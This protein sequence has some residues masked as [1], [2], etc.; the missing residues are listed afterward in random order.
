MLFNYQEILF[1]VLLVLAMFSL[2]VSIILLIAIKGIKRPFSFLL[3]TR[4]LLLI[5][6]FFLSRSIILHSA[7]ELWSFPTSMG[8][9]I[10]IPLIY[11]YLLDLMHS[12]YMTLKTIFYCTIPLVIL[13]VSYLLIRFTQN[14]L[15]RITNYDLFFQYVRTPEMMLRI[16]ALTAP[17]IETLIMAIFLFKALKEYRHRINSDFSYKE[18]IDLRWVYIYVCVLILYVLFTCISFMSINFYSD[19]IALSLFS[20]VPQVSMILVIQQKNIYTHPSKL[21][22]KEEEIM[23]QKTGETDK[24]SSKTS[25]LKHELLQLLEVEEIY[26]EQD[27]SA[28]KICELLH[29]NRTYLSQ[30]IGNEFETNFYGLIN[31]YRCQKAISLMKNAQIT[32]KYTLKNIAE[33]SGFKSQGTFITYFKEHMGCTPSEWLKNNDLKRN[34]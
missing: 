26:K 31:T 23:D 17:C 5:F 7:N 22:P 32:E 34:I 15:P 16:I 20:I 27:L 14:P 19:I 12:K 2:L 11:F 30:L 9:L 25:G 8:A 13:S 33:L 28:E 6:F 10:I 18:G 24:K 1:F 21:L 29:T 3:I 4:L